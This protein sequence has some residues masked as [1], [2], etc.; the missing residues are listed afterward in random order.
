MGK[1]HTMLFKTL[2]CW[3]ILMLVQMTKLIYN[4]HI[5]CLQH[6]LHLTILLT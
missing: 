6:G 5:V 3:A 1:D 2:K 4:M